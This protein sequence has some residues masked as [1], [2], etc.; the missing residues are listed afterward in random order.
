MYRKNHHFPVIV[1]Q[2]PG[3]PVGEQ[4]HDQLTAD[5]QAISEL[6]V[7][8]EISSVFSRNFPAA[9]FLSGT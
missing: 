6:V 7:P 1:S 8:A 5:V 4:H 3:E 9:M 2:N